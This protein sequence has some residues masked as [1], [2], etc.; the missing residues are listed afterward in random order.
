MAKASA[1]LKAALGTLFLIYSEA[2]LSG[3]PSVPNI[4]KSYLAERLPYRR[5]TCD[6]FFTAFFRNQLYEC[7]SYR[8]VSV[9]RF[10]PTYLL[11][12]SINTLTFLS[13]ENLDCPTSIHV[14]DLTQFLRGPRC[15]M[16]LQSIWKSTPTYQKVAWIA[17]R[18]MWL[19]VC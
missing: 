10:C 9:Q 15:C 11:V 3:T 19:G 18:R 13:G 5:S 16:A 8:G 12:M 6:A 2:S 4:D 1:R 17:R 7:C 14:I